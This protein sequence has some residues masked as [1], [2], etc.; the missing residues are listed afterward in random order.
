MS[1]RAKGREVSS[2]TR[3]LVSDVVELH[4]DGWTPRRSLNGWTKS[5][6][7]PAKLS[8]SDVAAV[9]KLYGE[10]R[11]EFVGLFRGCSYNRVEK[12]VVEAVEL[13][14]KGSEAEV[15]SLTGGAIRE[16]I[17]QRLLLLK[18]L[19]P[20]VGRVVDDLVRKVG[21]PLNWTSFG[22]IMEIIYNKG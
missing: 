13:A 14:V 9:V 4:G 21:C 20:L 17:H 6:A 12:F 22:Q 8:V 7:P 16:L 2:R 15:V 1:E 18:R 5:I 11:K 19:R 10:N 3:A